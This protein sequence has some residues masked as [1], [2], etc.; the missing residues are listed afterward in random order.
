MLLALLLLA[1]AIEFVRDIFGI[2]DFVGY[3]NAGN[4]VLKGSHIYSD[5]LN[6][7]PPL[8]S[9]FSVPLALIDNVNGVLMRSI[10]LSASVICLFFLMKTTVKMI[11]GR[12]LLIPFQTT[13]NNEDIAFHDWTILLPFV[14]V[15]RY[16]LDN[17][18][19]IQINIFMLG[20]A[21]AAL[22]YH[23]KNKD[24]AASFWLSLSIS[25]K[26]FT[27]FLLPFLLVR[28]RFKIVLFSFLWII[29][30]NALPFIVFGPETALQYYSQFFRDRAEPFAMILHK[31]Q[32]IFAMFRSIFMNE[33]RGLE[34]YLN[35]LD[36]TV[37]EAKRY[38]YI[39]A[40]LLVGAVLW[41]LN[42]VQ[43]KT[44]A[45][46]LSESLLVLA[47]L[48][49]FSPLAWKAY[50]IF[51]WPACYWICY[52]VVRLRNNKEKIPRTVYVL[53]VLFFIGT[54]L[55]TEGIIGGYL[56]DLTEVLAFIT[57]G[58]LALLTSHLILHLKW[59]GVRAKKA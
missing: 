24:F 12:N 14:L 47:A 6:T 26:V 29:L 19:N 23:Y 49:I 52:S 53:M 48:P 5:Y 41:L 46:F 8:F 10:W 54:T 11:S 43:P 31:N 50:F 42:R 2:G 32:S 21:V 30:L 55:T 57:L 15:F 44:E 3:V 13:L 36:L 34:I 22:N 1:V 9:I 4:N 37:E 35:V 20:M 16:I 38:S 27:I 40:G 59:F 33:S 7:W 45:S 28:K 17:M 39:L 25:L 56:S 18:A 58:T 51:L